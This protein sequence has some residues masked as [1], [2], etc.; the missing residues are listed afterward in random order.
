MLVCMT[1]R[2]ESIASQNFLFSIMEVLEDIRRESPDQPLTREELTGS[3]HSFDSNKLL[4]AM[5]YRLSY[6]L[7]DWFN[8]TL[9]DWLSPDLLEMY[10]AVLLV[11]RM[12]GSMRKGIIT[13]IY[14]EKDDI[15]NWSPISLLNV[16][17]RS[18]PTPSPT[19]SSLL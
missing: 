17:V 7:M 11:G 16:N 10:G 5:T 12:S 15:W 19:G 8:Y 18:C 6:T 13:L 4:K 14:K 2:P 1:E 3:I 9:L